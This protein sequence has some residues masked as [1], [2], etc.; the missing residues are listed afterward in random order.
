MS[1]IVLDFENI[2]AY[3]VLKVVGALSATAHMENNNNKKQI[4]GGKNMARATKTG[5]KRHCQWGTLLKE[6][7]C[8][9]T[10]EQ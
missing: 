7:G 10:T 2:I 3:M 5:K 8:G 1:K 6:A 9:G 4:K